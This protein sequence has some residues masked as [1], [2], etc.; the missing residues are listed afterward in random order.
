MF[1]LFLVASEM[2]VKCRSLF[3]CAWDN[4]GK[5]VSAA[6]TIRYI[7][8]TALR[9]QWNISLRSHLTMH[10][11]IGLTDYYW[12]NFAVVV[13]HRC[14]RWQPKLLMYN[15]VCACHCAVRSRRRSDGWKA[16]TQEVEKPAQWRIKVEKECAVVNPPDFT[17]CAVFRWQGE[18]QDDRK[19]QWVAARCQSRTAGVL[20]AVPSAEV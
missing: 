8:M 4:G 6:T 11:A 10:R 16:H 9:I 12:T 18:D 20:G 7:N 2:S 17:Q 13:V 19:T 1:T 5:S 3:S 15:C 14:R